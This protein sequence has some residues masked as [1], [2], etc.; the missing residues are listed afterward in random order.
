M[1]CGDCKFWG[2]PDESIAKWRSC[3][4]VIHDDEWVTAPT[5]AEGGDA[6]P[7]EERDYLRDFRKK[8]LLIIRDQHRAVVVDDSGYHAALKTRDSFGCV[9][10]SPR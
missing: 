9:L 8:E 7:I 1:R 10:F 5:V 6:R 3:T 4:A 2:L